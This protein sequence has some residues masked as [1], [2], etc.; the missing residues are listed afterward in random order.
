[1]ETALSDS[2]AAEG[3]RAGGVES[4]ALK[5][6]AH[7]YCSVSIGSRHSRC[8]MLAQA[9]GSAELFSSGGYQ[10]GGACRELYIGDNLGSGGLGSGVRQGFRGAVTM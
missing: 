5:A 7:T 10:H 2:A 6:R 1:M 8:I 4:L 9:D 3:F